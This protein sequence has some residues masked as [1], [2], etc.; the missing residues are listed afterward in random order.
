[1]QA[2]WRIPGVGVVHPSI[3]RVVIVS[4]ASVG[5]LKKFLPL[6]ILKRGFHSFEILTYSGPDPHLRSR[7][8][9]VGAGNQRVW[10]LLKGHEHRLRQYWITQV[11]F[12]FDVRNC[13]LEDVRTRLLA[14][15]ARLD[16]RRHQ[17]GYIY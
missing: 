3:D 13:R 6:A 2:A 8:V 5:Y 10:Q 1:M 4:T 7:I 14:L 12:A 11:E 17:R 16:K 15:V 9:A